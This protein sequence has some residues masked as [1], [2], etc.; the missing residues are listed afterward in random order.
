MWVGCTTTPL[1]HRSD[2]Y[3]AANLKAAQKLLGGNWPTLRI[4]LC[5]E[6]MHA[7]ATLA[8]D[9]SGGGTVAFLGSANLVRGTDLHPGNGWVAAI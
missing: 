8:H 1:S 4:Y 9:G 6:M 3:L 5:P 2:P 7:K